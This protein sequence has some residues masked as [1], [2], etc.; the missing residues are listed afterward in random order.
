MNKVAE[1][2]GNASFH[3][4]HAYRPNEALHWYAI[5]HWKQRGIEVLDWGGRAESG[6]W[7]EKYNPAPIS[8]PKFH[9]SR[10]R[11]LDTM[12]AQMQRLI[13]ARQL[14]LGAFERWFG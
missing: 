13:A 3:S 6:D 4:G 8:I 7:K 2:W 10:Y 5:R 12:R 9:K 11:V 1:F 14:L